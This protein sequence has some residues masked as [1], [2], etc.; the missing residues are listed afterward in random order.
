MPIESVQPFEVRVER[1]DGAVVLE[2]AGELDLAVGEEAAAA[3]ADAGCD[4]PPLIVL[5]LQGLS[6]M[7][8]TGLHCLERAKAQADAVGTRLAI[9]NGSGPAH[10]LLSLTRMDDVIEMVDDLTQ[11]DPPMESAA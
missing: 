5:N 9:L 4:V 10:K 7:D 2:F 8:S 3:L 11:L 6:F 1:R